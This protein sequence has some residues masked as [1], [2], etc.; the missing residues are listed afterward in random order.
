MA[1]PITIT[2]LGDASKLEQT[3]ATASSKLGTFAQVGG[4]ALLGVGTAA[5][6][7]GVGAIA[8]A[9]S[10][11][12]AYD[13]IR[14][15]TGATGEALEGL[16]A[17]FKNV[18][19]NVPTDFGSAS[20]AIADLN[21]RLGLTGKPLEDISTQVLNLSRITGTDVATNVEAVSRL[22]GDWSVATGDQ[23]TSLDALFRA[24]QATGPSVDRLGQ[25][26]VQ[27]GAPLRQLGF[28]FEESAALLGKFEKE[29][30]NTELVMGSMR[31]ALGR[32]ARAG[33]EPIETFQRVTEEIKNAGTAGEANSLALEMFGARAGPDM[34]AAIREGRFELGDLL[35]VVEGGSETINGAAEDTA[36]WQ[37]KLQ[38]LM[39]RVM[40]RLEPIL[41]KVFDALTN[42][43]EAMGPVVD[44]V[45]DAIE[46]F[47]G[48]GLE[49]LSAFIEEKFGPNSNVT[50]V[51]NAFVQAFHTIRRVVV[52]DVV[53]AVRS[54][55]QEI[56]AV[57]SNVWAAISALWD[58]FGAT[59]MDKVMD[60]FRF[61]QRTVENVLQIIQGVWN[62]FVGVFTGDWSQAWDGIRGIFSGVW[63]QILNVLRFAWEGI[64]SA[65]R[66]ILDT[67][68]G[69]WNWDFLRN[70]VGGAV[71]GVVGFISGLPG[72][73]AGIIGNVLQ[74]GRD[75]GAN[76]LS[77][78]LDGLGAITSAAFNLAGDFGSALLG[79]MKS[80]WNSLLNT[81]NSLTNAAEIDLPGP[82]PTV[83]LPDNMWN[84]FK[85]R[86]MGGP[87]DGW[88]WVGERGPELVRLPRGSD[89]TPNHETGGKGGVNV[90]VTTQADPWAIGQEVSWA[91][92]TSG[93]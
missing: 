77:G 24:S 7:L 71:D 36:G 83:G 93:R 81:L 10:F 46:V 22:F 15:G 74:A 63:D 14:V 4:A 27:Y 55:I 32:M 72:R 91:M 62:T 58:T 79:A 20:T 39:N 28:G 87:A 65:V 3:L 19:S 12:D 49:G 41:M 26:M 64:K 84:P 6:G 90:Y 43:L 75:I 54:A 37:E 42:F 88:T 13:T 56:S 40:V 44:T 38:V 23:A 33:E 60:T 52:N 11:D 51:F 34:A 67:V 86:A 61:V 1:K 2:I 47:Q 45:M 57:W 92:K 76:L 30:V 9:G 16:E 59:I 31:Q 69:L 89:V 53:P 8:M 48:E 25:L 5:V 50:R 78:M 66:L 82:L 85:F 21:T 80:A 35:G 17:S 18:V 73:I 68:R 29:G 70:A